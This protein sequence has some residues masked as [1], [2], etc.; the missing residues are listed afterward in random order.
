MNRRL[1]AAIVT[2]S[3]LALLAPACSSPQACKDQQFAGAARLDAYMLGLSPKF[4]PHPPGFL[5][6]GPTHEMII[7]FA[8]DTIGTCGQMVCA[9]SPE[10][11]RRAFAGTIGVDAVTAQTLFVYHLGYSVLD[12]LASNVQGTIYWNNIGHPCV[13]GFFPMTTAD[14]GP[15][16]GADAGACANLDEN[17]SH[18]GQGGVPDCCPYQQVVPGGPGSNLE[19]EPNDIDSVDTFGVCRVA[20]AYPCNTKDDCFQTLTPDGTPSDC[21]DVC[22]FE[23]GRDCW[24]PGDPMTEGGG[25]CPG[26]MCVQ[27]VIGNGWWCQP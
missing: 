8:A 24:T 19:C 17:C 20:L 16:T 1:I 22:C 26:T 4:T 3:T 23:S 27:D 5:D 14:A 18:I 15:S 9:D 12:V 11:A 13:G 2:G 10:S 7:Q 21:H 25:C 6:L